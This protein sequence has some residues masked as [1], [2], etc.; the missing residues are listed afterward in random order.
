MWTNNLA[1]INWKLV[2]AQPKEYTIRSKK[3]KFYYKSTLLQRFVCPRILSNSVW[4]HEGIHFSLCKMIE[5]PYDTF[6]VLTYYLSLGWATKW[7]EKFS[8]SGVMLGISIHYHWLNFF[9]SQLP[10]FFKKNIQ[11][12]QILS[13]WICESGNPLVTVN[14]KRYYRFHKHKWLQS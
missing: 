2:G 8:K 7:H 4:Y 10:Q 14:L 3:N 13:L 1:A 6:C 12:S 9:S 5:E 11:A